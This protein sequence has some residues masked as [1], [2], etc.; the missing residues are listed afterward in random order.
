MVVRTV[1][2]VA[3]RLAL[4]EVTVVLPVQVPVVDVVD[5]VAVR[6]PDV[7]AA[8][9]VP[10]RV[11]AVLHVARCH[12]IRLLLRAVFRAFSRPAG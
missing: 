4:V 8:L 9:A 2:V 3:F 12:G 11:L 5:V 1:L 6:H 10:V 7:S